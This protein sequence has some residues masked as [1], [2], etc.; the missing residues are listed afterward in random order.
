LTPFLKE[1]PLD[2]TPGEAFTLFRE[3]PWSFL[4]ESGMN[5]FQLGRFSF[6]GGEPFLTF[7]AR[8]EMI[9]IREDDQSVTFR[10]DPLEALRLLLARFRVHWTVRPAP[11][12]AGAV[13]FFSYDLSRSIECL[14]PLSTD[15]LQVPD[16]LLG[17]YDQALLF[18]HVKG[19]LYVASTGLPEL[20]PAAAHRRA[21]RRGQELIRRLQRLEEGR[22]TGGPFDQRGLTPAGL[23]TNF[24]KE[25]YLNAV[26]RA[27]EYIAAGDIYQVNLSQRFCT[28]FQ[29]DPFALYRRLQ[30]INPAPFGCFL[31]YGDVVV[32]GGSPERFLRLRGRRVETRP[33]KGTRP[34]GKSPAEDRYL[35]QEL[36]SSEKDRAELVMIVDLERNDLGRVCDYGSVRVRTL[37]A[38]ETYATVFQTTAT[39]LG[40]LRQDRD[41][42]DLLRACF[43]GG[44]VTGAPKIRAMEIIEELEPTRRGI[45]TGSIGYLD[46]DGDLDLNIAIRTMI[47]RDRQAYFQV[48][49]GIV[50]DS[51]PE[52]EYE[53]TLVKAKA[54]IEA[55]FS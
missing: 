40:R 14:P 21:T 30:R 1:Y 28:P 25:E 44:S 27:K 54:L 11:F 52:A 16:C 36:L 18:D 41:R 17:F 20:N 7:R 46:L 42:I 29:G 22:R 43:P 15:D 6:L 55:L 4:L 45:Y 13:G 53:E 47:C 10:A 33:M 37:R 49:G 35:R 51:D 50:A 26:R 2:I 9:E 24:T 8:G 31:D 3:D 12:L 23:H 38:L 32:V 34:R 5:R 19:R 39:I 48:G